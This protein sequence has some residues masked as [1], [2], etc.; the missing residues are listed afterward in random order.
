MIYFFTED[1]MRKE[2]ETKGLSVNI[3]G[4]RAKIIGGTLRLESQIQELNY[5]IL[6]TGIVSYSGVQLLLVNSL[7]YRKMTAM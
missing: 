7:D 6:K 3:S 1:T 2:S 4:F 5:Q